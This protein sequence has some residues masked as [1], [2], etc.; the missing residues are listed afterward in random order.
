MV[1]SAWLRV[2]GDF[3]VVRVAAAVSRIL[4]ENELCSMASV[5]ADQTAHCNTAFFCRNGLH[6]LFFISHVDSKHAR[7]YHANAASTWTVFSTQQVWG[8][9]LAGLQ[10]RGRTAVAGPI[11][12][13]RGVKAYSSRFPGFAESVLTTP[14][15]DVISGDY[16]FFR[17]TPTELTLFD[18]AEFGEETYVRA[19]VVQP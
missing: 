13:L 19:H 3:D 9:P 5:G 1:E 6:E 12:S 10:L 7:N 17:F 14:I 15:S 11:E 4:S 16:R 8:K 2:D 18:E